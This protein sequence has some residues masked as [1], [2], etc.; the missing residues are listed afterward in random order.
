[1][2]YFHCYPQGEEQLT[3]CKRS[4]LHPLEIRC[5][6]FQHFSA[7]NFV[8][9]GG[10]ALTLLENCTPDS[11]ELWTMFLLLCQWN[12]KICL[13][14]WLNQNLNPLVFPH[15]W[16]VAISWGAASP[17]LPYWCLSTWTSRGHFWGG[18]NFIFGAPP[19]YFFISP[20]NTRIMLLLVGLGDDSST[21]NCTNTF[22]SLFM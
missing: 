2:K 9:S 13:H 11:A 1:M 18:G 17:V 4:K 15:N 14:V 8:L 10:V 3:A 22:K 21:R 20:D 6:D 7:R 5:S 16:F 19:V 12:L